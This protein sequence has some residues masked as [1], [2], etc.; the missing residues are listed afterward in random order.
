M[1]GRLAAAQFAR[2]LS[3]D[4][5][6]AIGGTR[7]R[8]ARAALQGGPPP[9]SRSTPRRSRACSAAM[10]GAGSPGRLPP[11]AS[12]SAAPAATATTR[13]WPSRLR[14]TLRAVEF[15][16]RRAGGHLLE[17]TDVRGKVITRR[18]GA[19]YVFPVRGNAP[20]TFDGIDRETGG[21]F[22]EARPTDASSSARYV[23]LEDLISYP[24]V[25]RIARIKRYRKPPGKSAS[26]AASGN[27]HTGTSSPRSMHNTRRQRNCCGRGLW[28]T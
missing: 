4:E 27:D 25:S 2:S 10:A 7:G 23:P 20:E 8:A 9:G 3:R 26:G 12:A 28:K 22:K 17:R 16:R 11:T 5:L 15:R 18:C 21:R 14:R 19:D 13:P 6:E 24:G 1:K